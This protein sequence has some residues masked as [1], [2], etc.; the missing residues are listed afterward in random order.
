[1]IEIDDLR[2]VVAR[3]L[4]DAAIFALSADNRLGL[5]YEAVLILSKMSVHAAGYR[6][7]SGAV[8]AHKVTLQGAE[9]AIGPS[10]ANTIAYFDRLRRMRNQLS[11]DVAG[12]TSDAEAN[13][14]LAQAQA[15]QTLVEGWIAANHPTLV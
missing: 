6:V 9:I 12:S 10:I 7:R 4:A 3:N 8:G 5:A 11:Y 15:F 1:M 2:G 13:S 14:A